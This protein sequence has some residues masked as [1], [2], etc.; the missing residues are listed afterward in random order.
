M[1]L[2]L[3]LSMLVLPLVANGARAQC[4]LD[5][6]GD[7]VVEIQTPVG[8][9]CI[10][11]FPEAPGFTETVPNFLGY[12]NRGDYDGT[13]VH[14]S[15]PGFVIQG[16][17]LAFEAGEYRSIC[18]DGCPTVD[19]EFAGVS[20]LLGCGPTQPEGCNV[21]GTLA[22]AKLGGN[23]D[24]ATSQWFINLSD[25]NVFLDDLDDLGDLD[26]ETNSGEFT[27]FGRVVTGMDVADAIAGLPRTDG[28]FADLV[29]ETELW[30]ALGELPLTSAP[31]PSCFDPSDMAIV[32]RAGETGCVVENLEPDPV[33]GGIY[34]VSPPCF[35]APA[36][37]PGDPLGLNTCGIVR[38]TS[39]GQLF[40]N[41]PGL[42]SSCEAREASDEA[43]ATLA[44][45]VPERL[46]EISRAFVVPE[47]RP[48]LSGLA[49]LATLG[50][51]ARRRC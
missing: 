32:L 4:V 51:V 47:P 37:C 7:P 13:F 20:A 5:P 22:M 6:G 36:T 23:L 21:R 1:R 40:F 24:S 31:P 14:R 39:D 44:A 18:E 17:G 11:L 45:Q 30:P 15:V 34:L 9:I 50:L 10:Q 29:L 16:G 48:A 26:P 2:A 3:V 43:Q 41:G 42:P 49:A 25:Q 12:V 19:N 28:E 27:V 8:T 33:T 38:R 46:V 35:G